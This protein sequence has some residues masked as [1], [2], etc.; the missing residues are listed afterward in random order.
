MGK[1]DSEAEKAAQLTDKE[2]K[3]AIGELINVEVT[4]LFPNTADQEL[5]NELIQKVNQSTN[6]NEMI[7]ACQAIAVKLTA[8]GAKALK[9]GLKIGKALV[10]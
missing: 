2:L 4:S 6:R 5:V 10:L 1:Y 9:E 7:T 3:E 8:E